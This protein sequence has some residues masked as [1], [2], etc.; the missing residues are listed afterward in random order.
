MN[1]AREALARGSTLEDEPDLRR[2][3]LMALAAAEQACLEAGVTSAKLPAPS[4]R[5]YRYLKSLDLAPVSTAGVE[6][7]PHPRRPSAGRLVSA[8]A[9][10]QREIGGLARH[11]AS[12]KTP[13]PASEVQALRARIQ[14][15]AAETAIACER[16]GGGPASLPEPSRRV[17]QWLSFLACGAALTDHLKTLGRLLMVDDRVAV[18]LFHT[19]SLYSAKPQ[20]D[21]IRLVVSE[22]F[23]G[24]PPPV[25]E[26]L[27]KLSLPYT[28]KRK[29]R[30]V[31]NAYVDGDAFQ[32]RILRLE[33]S[34]DAFDLEPKGRAYDLEEIFAHLNRAYFQGRLRKPRLSWNRTITS[35]EFG[36][37]EPSTDTVTISIVL[38]SAEVPRSVVEYVL[39]HELLHKELGVERVNG[40]RRVH[41]RKFRERERRFPRAGEAEAFLVGLTKRLQRG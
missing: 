1:Q 8:R 9:T 33:Q 7:E 2:A 29:H 20:G 19:A 31:V 14:E 10:L 25:L 18:E 39:H 41:T 4:R 22:G 12:T 37:Y 11:A 28:R 32:E 27:V 15:V 34:G 38:D 23:V 5:A 30:G 16:A 17:Y 21:G 6:A 40:R 36:R 35:R 26:S 13:I 3:V 24:A